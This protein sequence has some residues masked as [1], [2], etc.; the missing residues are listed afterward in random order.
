KRQVEDDPFS[1]KLFS[2]ILAD[3]IKDVEIHIAKNFDEALKMVNNVD[4]FSLFILD[5][6]LG[7]LKNGIDIYK[8]LYKSDNKPIVL[9]TSTVEEEKFKNLFPPGMVA[10]PYL[11]KPFNPIACANL[12]EA[13]I[14]SRIV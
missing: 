12:V 5:I 4:H 8:T 11:K 1:I 13:L 10:P 7:G 9:M 3:N 14:E 6:N 2:K